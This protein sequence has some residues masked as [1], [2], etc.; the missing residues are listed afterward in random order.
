MS[1]VTTRI[2][3]QYKIIV[4]GFIAS[5]LRVVFHIFSSK[6]FIRGHRKKF[7]TERDSYNF[8]VAASLTFSRPFFVENVKKFRFVCLFD[9]SNN[10]QKNGRY[11]VD[12]SF[13]RNAWLNKYIRDKKG[14]FLFNIF[15][16]SIFNRFT[17]IQ[18]GYRMAWQVLSIFN[19][20]KSEE[21]KFF[22]KLKD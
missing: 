12:Y 21:F 14:F 4:N 3:Q 18:S 5:F 19:K 10:K 2:Q 15:L 20:L 8:P 6:K 1:T 13:G 11:L 7:L 16:C 17:E 9:C 22:L